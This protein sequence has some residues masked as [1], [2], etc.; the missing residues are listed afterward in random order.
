MGCARLKGQ[1]CSLRCSLSARIEFTRDIDVEPFARSSRARGPWW[2][3]GTIL[4]LGEVILKLEH[5]HPRLEDNEFWLV[6][7]H[8]D[9]TLSAIKVLARG[10]PELLLNPLATAGAPEVLRKLIVN[11][12]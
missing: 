7:H 1:R 10:R 9:E 6:P 3:V 8:Q 2:R 12:G 4:R 5:Y 11:N